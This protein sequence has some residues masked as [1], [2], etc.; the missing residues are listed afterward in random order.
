MTHQTVLRALARP[1]LSAP[2]CVLWLVT[3]G[4]GQASSAGGVGASGNS[5]G[6]GNVGSLGGSA[7]SNVGGSDDSTG[8][9]PAGGAAA[10]AGA[11]GGDAGTSASGATGSN[12]GSTAGAGGAGGAGGANAGGVNLWANVSKSGPPAWSGPTVPGTVS[13]S[14]STV[15]KLARG[16]VGLSYEKSHLTDQYF[17]GNN[18][19]LI[20]MFKLLGPSNMRIGGTS[21]DHTG[22]QASAPAAAANALSTTVGTADIDAL[23]S[24]L[25]AT[26][27]TVLYGINLKTATPQTDAAEAAYAAGKLGTNLDAFEIGNEPDLYSQTYAVWSANWGSV[28]TAIQGM[29][30]KAPL[31]GPATAGGGIAEAV[32]LAHD[33]ASRLTVMTQHYYRGAGKT[34]DPTSVT[35]NTLVSPD[36]GLIK[37]L[38]QLST[39]AT[40]NHL[41]GGFRIGELASFFSGGAPGVSNAFGSALWA[42]DCLFDNAENG[43][44]GVNFHG[45]GPGQNGSEQFYYS[46][47]T[48]AAGVVTGVGPQFYGMLLVTSAGTGNVL[49]TTAQAG[50]LNFS[51]HAVAQADG[52]TNIALNNKDT[53]SAV[54]V[55]LSVGKTPSS[56]S[57]VFLTGPSLLATTGVTFAG[58][59][60]SATGAWAPAPAWT[61]PISGSTISIVVPP[62]SAALVHVQ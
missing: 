3:S 46:P 21:V 35:M 4:C 44:S 13:V 62:A 41:P 51:A 32:E 40:S 11:G 34:T 43:S 45:G 54:T 58:A 27:W 22:W 15:G 23:A 56:A 14:Q 57:A 50:K 28:A 9:V 10:T 24:F 53:T 25:E 19:A 7:G 42:I 55:T 60:I 12:G 17:S 61:L 52:S 26:Q 36:P 20:A 1:A 33:E 8:G 38:G 16:F 31:A 59:A 29:V 6:T 18:A 30:P 39:G 37:K 2:I 48:E 47:I 49:A 5:G